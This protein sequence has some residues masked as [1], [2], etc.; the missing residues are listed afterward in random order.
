[1]YSS[2]TPGGGLNSDSRNA[3]I[4]LASAPWISHE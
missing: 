3:S 1:M 4:A 2:L